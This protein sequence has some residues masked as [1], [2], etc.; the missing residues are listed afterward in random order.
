MKYEKLMQVMLRVTDTYTR[1]PC[2][3]VPPKA[4][5]AY[6]CWD[7]EYYVMII[8]RKTLKI[9]QGCLK[10]LRGVKV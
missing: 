4:R 9:L 5:D 3:A 1:L 7:G 6:G 10:M 2:C 8:R